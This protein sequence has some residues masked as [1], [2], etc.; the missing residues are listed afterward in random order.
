[1]KI[2][3]KH[4]IKGY[5]GTGVWVDQKWKEMFDT[6]KLRRSTGRRMFILINKSKIRRIMSAAKH[7]ANFK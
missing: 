2:F 4:K 6:E 3:A 1:M 5:K 7:P